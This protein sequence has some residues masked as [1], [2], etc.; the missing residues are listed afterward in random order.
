MTGVFDLPVLIST[1][2]TNS[3]I[4]NFGVTNWQ[5]SKKIPICQ[6]VALRKKKRCTIGVKQTRMPIGSNGLLVAW[7]CV[8]WSGIVYQLPIFMYC[9]APSNRLLQLVRLPFCA[10]PF[11]NSVRKHPFTT[12]SIS[13]TSVFLCGIFSITKI[14]PAT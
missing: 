1:S 8:T 6:I 4:R 11:S 5:E 2:V 9:Y 13:V 10:D 7:H 14:L 3:L 12:V